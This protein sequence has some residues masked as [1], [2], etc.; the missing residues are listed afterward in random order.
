MKYIKKTI[1]LGISFYLDAEMDITYLFNVSRPLFPIFIFDLCILQVP[2]NFY[3]ILISTISK[4]E[5]KLKY[6]IVIRYYNT[7]TRNTSILTDYKK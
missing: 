7:T 5:L 2:I 3:N 1:F 6:C 4:L